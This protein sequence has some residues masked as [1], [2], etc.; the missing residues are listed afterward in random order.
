MVENR[1][2]S[3][4]PLLMTSSSEMRGAPRAARSGDESQERMGR[5]HFVARYDALVSHGKLR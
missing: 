1:L 2:Y 3:T 4:K 5:D